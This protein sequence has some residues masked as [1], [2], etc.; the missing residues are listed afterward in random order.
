M[1]TLTALAGRHGHVRRLAHPRHAAEKWDMPMAYPATNYHSENGVAFAKCVTDG[2]GGE[3]EI[4]THPGG[5]L[6][7]GNDIKRAVQTGQ[8]PIGERLLSAHANENPLFGVDSI[9]FLATSFADSDKLLEGGEG[10]RERCA[11]RAEPGLCL[12]GAVAAAG[13]L[14]QEGS[15][16]GRRHEGHQVPR[17]QRRHRAHRRTG[18]HG[19]GADRGGRTEP[20]AGDRR[21]RKLHLVGLDRRRFQG[22]G[23]PDPFLRRAGLAAAQ[24]RLRQQGRLRRARR[25]RRRR[26]SWIAAT[27]PRRPARPRPRN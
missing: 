26:R 23:K 20:G 5:S 4:V 27:R 13:P 10:C 8:A 6:F 25:R 16:L 11:R 2:T 18:R 19:A 7:A 15:E 24:R 3:L 17:L 22:L 14:L 9:P 21:R 1:K 12:L